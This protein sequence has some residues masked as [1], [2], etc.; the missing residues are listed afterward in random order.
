MVHSGISD[1]CQ[2][3]KREGY[4]ITIETAATIPP[5]GID[6]DLASLSPKL[7]NSTPRK[8]EISEAWRQRHEERRWRPDIIRQWLQN[9]PFQLKFVVESPGDLPEIQQQLE[10]ISP[11]EP[12]QVFL[13]P[14]GIT[15]SQLKDKMGWLSELCRKFGYRLAPRLHIDLYGNKP[16]T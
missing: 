11:V 9:Y 15:P 7:S 8:G 13:M 5:A 1:L 14:E 2:S 16:G 10:S 6:C 4:H 12:H 3:L